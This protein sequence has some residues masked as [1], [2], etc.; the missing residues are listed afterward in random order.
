MIV[1]ERLI[2]FGFVNIENGK[3]EEIVL[4]NDLYFYFIKIV[5][6]KIINSDNS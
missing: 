3:I 2:Y 5:G 4:N 6:N 1:V